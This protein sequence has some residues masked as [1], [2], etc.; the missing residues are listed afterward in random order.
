[1]SLN[2]RLRPGFCRFSLTLLMLSF[3][4]QTVAGEFSAT[5]IKAAY[6]YNFAK[7]VEWPEQLLPADNELSLCVMGDSD[8]GT[9][10]AELD[11]KQAGERVV[12]V[13]QRHYADPALSGCRILFI[14]RSEHQRFVMTLKALTDL[15]VL[16]LSDIQDFA[17][18]GGAIGLAVRDD[19]I[20]FEVNLESIRKAG[21]RVP[22]QLLNIAAYV[23]GR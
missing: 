18:K 10:L 19:K 16:T 11:G 7:F 6:L 1:M 8:M 15:P 2:F 23:Y 22:G 9:A 14:G 21:L 3:G 20:V 12:R 4:A 17:E 13:V 5:Q